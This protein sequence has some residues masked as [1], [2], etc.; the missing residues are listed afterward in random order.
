MTESLFWGK[1]GSA[2]IE[3]LASIDSRGHFPCPPVLVIK[4][5]FIFPFETPPNSSNCDFY[6]ILKVHW[7]NR[8]NRIIGFSQ[9]ITTRFQ[10][11]Q[12]YRWDLFKYYMKQQNF[13]V[14]IF[15]LRSI[16][17]F[18]SI[19]KISS[20]VM[21]YRRISISPQI[22]KLRTSNQFYHFTMTWNYLKYS[23][24]EGK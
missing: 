24:S 12:V 15:F 21:M 11:N 16:G 1:N 9:K 2:K 22:K 7:N 3:Y 18:D 13:E 8:I 23:G 10:W 4:K 14:Q 20:I 5:Q 17:H 6:S 19:L